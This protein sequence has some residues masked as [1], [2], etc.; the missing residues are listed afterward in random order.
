MHHPAARSTHLQICRLGARTESC[1]GLL[2]CRSV[3]MLSPRP[4]IADPFCPIQYITPP[5]ISAAVNCLYAKHTLACGS[6]KVLIRRRRHGERSGRAPRHIRGD[7]VTCARPIR[8]AYA[9]QK[10][11]CW[12]VGFDCRDRCV[13]LGFSFRCWNRLGVLG[14]YLRSQGRYWSIFARHRCYFDWPVSNMES[15]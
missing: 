2:N 8:T 15:A 10:R 5:I 12:L 1:F 13:C 3:G 14:I 6:S 7:Y 9:Y 4:V 11:L